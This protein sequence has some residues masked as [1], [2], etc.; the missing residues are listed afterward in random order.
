MFFGGSLVYVQAE[1]DNR[2]DRARR[3]KHVCS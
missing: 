2:G 3:E 1:D